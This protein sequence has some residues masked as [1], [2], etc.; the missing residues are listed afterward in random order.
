MTRLDSRAWLAWAVAA[1]L[2]ALLGRNP[3]LLV[4]L[5]IIVLIVHTVWANANSFGG[6]HWFV[7]IAAAFS[8][9]GIIFNVLTVHA[10]TSVFATLPESWPLI[11]GVL[12]LNALLYGVASGIAL[13]TLVLIGTTVGSLVN[14]MDLFHVMPPRL[15]PIAVAG[16]VA[17]AFLP[18]TAVA[19]RQIRESQEMRGHRVHGVRGLLPLIVPLISGALER[20]LSVAE[21]LEARGFGASLD[22]EATRRETGRR[23]PIL[24]ICALVL[25]ISGAFGTLTGNLRTGLFMLVIGAAVIG[26]NL[27]LP[28]GRQTRQTRYR[29][30]RWSWRD[31]I[32]SGTAV[33]SGVATLLASWFTPESLHFEPYPDLV[34]PSADASLMIAIAM[35][36]VPALTAPEQVADQTTEYAP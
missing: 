20:A 11:G 15:A 7:R 36:L 28:D 2:P 16:S 29:Q 30:T 4:E 19:F 25:L 34:V 10:G 8:L 5:L 1:M 13:F 27:R 12:T 31:S 23:A 26:I 33:V 9:I 17:W 32:I 24:V 3:F 6:I 22:L 18:Q 35:L 21:A 14:W